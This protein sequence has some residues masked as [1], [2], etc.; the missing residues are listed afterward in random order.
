[1][2]WH[3]TRKETLEK[4]LE[5]REI[6]GELVGMGAIGTAVGKKIMIGHMYVKPVTIISTGMV[7]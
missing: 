6:E 3:E 4:S 7:R 2:R 5:S 1:M